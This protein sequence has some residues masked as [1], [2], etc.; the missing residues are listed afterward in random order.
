[1]VLMSCKNL[2]EHFC[3][4]FSQWRDHTCTMIL[5]SHV[6]LVSGFVIVH[7]TD[8]FSALFLPVSAEGWQQSSNV[9]CY[10]KLGKP[11][12][13][14]YTHPHLTPAGTYRHGRTS[15]AGLSRLKEL[16]SAHRRGLNVFMGEGTGEE[17]VAMIRLWNRMV[18]Y[19]EIAVWLKT[20]LIFVMWTRNHRSLW[21]K[22]LRH[23]HSTYNW[24]KVDRLMP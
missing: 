13:T 3:C 7:G 8:H 11:S 23:K 9:T 10:L 12:H 16:P 24:K 21:N 18:L 2:I 22:D 14:Y 19:K 17:G 20:W 6:C 4:V 5:L 15:R 1:M